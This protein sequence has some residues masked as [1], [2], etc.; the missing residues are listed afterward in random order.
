MICDAHIHV[1]YYNRKGYVE[2]FYYSPRRICT[3]LKKCG[4]DEFIYSSTSMQTYGIDYSGVDREMLEVQKIFGIKAHP[5]L[6]VTRHYLSFNPTV[7]L[8]GFGFY[9]GVKLHGLDGSRWITENQESLE[10]VLASAARHDKRVMIHTGLEEDAR[11]INFLP[12]ILKYPEIRFNLAHGRPLDETEECMKATPNVF[13]DVSFMDPDVVLKFVED[14]WAGRLLW[15]T[16]IPALVSFSGES[17]T[18]VMREHV[19]FCKWLSAKIDFE[20]NFQRYL[21]GH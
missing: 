5:F 9:E 15:G 6:W 1:G 18:R 2:P 13:A 11:P 8:L 14:G 20:A 21:H 19:S 17:L 10:A 12:F 3:A 4:V 7:S 16:D